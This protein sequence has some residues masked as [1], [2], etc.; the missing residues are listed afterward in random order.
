MIFNEKESQ[1]FK[2]DFI[3]TLTHD[4]KT[5]VIA[6]LNTRTFFWK[7]DLVNSTKSKDKRLS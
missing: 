3:A 5:P 6:E 2:E 1:K 4:M 7:E